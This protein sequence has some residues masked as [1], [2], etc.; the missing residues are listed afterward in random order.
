MANDSDRV[1]LTTEEAL[2]M[3]PDGEYVHVFKNPNG[4]LVGCDW[5]RSDVVDLITR[6]GAELSGDI[7]TRMGHGIVCFEGNSPAFIATKESE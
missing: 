5:D 3:L 6:A 2:A 7:A 4:M 1:K